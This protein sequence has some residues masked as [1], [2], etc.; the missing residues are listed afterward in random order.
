MSCDSQCYLAVEACLV[1]LPVLT[2]N[3]ARLRILLCILPER[4][5]LLGCGH[6]HN[7]PHDITCNLSPNRRPC[8]DK[9]AS[10]S[11]L[12]AKSICHQES[13]LVK[14]TQDVQI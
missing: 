6:K 11:D 3:F 2:R 14:E 8:F 12:I 4:A 7:H 10:S 1:L 13:Q 9:D 5:G